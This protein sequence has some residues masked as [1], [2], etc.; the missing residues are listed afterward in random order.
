MTFIN[1]L[2]KFAALLMLVINFSN[3]N[4]M[5]TRLPEAGAGAGEKP[6]ASV[7]AVHISVFP[8]TTTVNACTPN[9][10]AGGPSHTRCVPTLSAEAENTL[11]ISFYDGESQR[12]TGPLDV[13]IDTRRRG[14]TIDVIS[15]IRIVAITP[16]ECGK[17][18]L[19]HRPMINPLAENPA[20]G[21]ASILLRHCLQK[22]PLMA[23]IPN[24]CEPLNLIDLATSG[25]K[26]L[27][28]L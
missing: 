14:G 19:T 1:N 15:P 5:D 16:S 23:C 9:T 22:S 6:R 26:I 21:S 25:E 11:D 8:L 24:R 12:N 7:W 3:I 4:A 10:N 27:R 13:A 20:G 18:T 2:Y 28:I 17:N